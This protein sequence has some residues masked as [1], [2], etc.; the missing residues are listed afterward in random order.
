[1]DNSEISGKNYFISDGKPINLWNWIKELLEKMDVPEITKEIPYKRAYTIGSIMELFYRILPI[2]GEPPMTRFVAIQLAH[3]HYFDISAA[4]KELGY[5]SVID[6]NQ[7][8]QDV[9][10]WLKESF[11][12]T[13]LQS[14]S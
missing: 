7:A 3:S 14:K 2:K 5:L 10:E 11:S 12:Y 6:Y 13:E 1:M 8:L 9:V 4:K